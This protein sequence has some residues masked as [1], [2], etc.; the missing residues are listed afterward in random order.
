M[1]LTVLIK[2]VFVT[3]CMLLCGSTNILK[4]QNTLDA[5][6]D[7]ACTNNIVLMQKNISLEKAQMALK[8]ANSFF[9]PS[10]NFQGAYQTA[11]G[12]RNIPLPLGDLLNPVYTTLNQITQSD[13]FPMLE[14]EQINFFPKNFYDA[15]L[16]ATIPL[17]NTDLTYNKK[18]VQK[19]YTLKEYEVAIY[20][21]ELVRNVKTAYYNYLSALQ[22]VEIYQSAMKLTQEALRV[23]EK[24]LEN[25]KGLPAYV[26]RSKSEIENVKAQI[27]TAEQQ[28]KNAK[29]YFN[30]LLN[31]EADKEI[32]VDFKVDDELHKVNTMLL[33]VNDASLREEIKL[34]NQV[35]AINR[36]VNKLNKLYAVPKLGAFI[37][38]G[39]QSEGFKFNQNSRYYMAGLQLEIPIFSGNRNSYKIRESNLDI[40]NAELNSS[41]VYQQLNLAVKVAQNNLL[42]ANQNYQSSL[43][44]FES[45]AAYQRLI[46]KGYLAGSNSFV[47]TID[48]R[49]QFTGSKILTQINKYKVLIALA[50][51]ERETAAYAIK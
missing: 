45:A 23:N 48:A 2:D 43:K 26:L 19:Q 40:K 10:L 14:N 6:I 41:L 11:D 30:F 27:V 25:G 50:D 44:Q 46:D 39:S 5:Y 42:S 15:K 4:A 22:A 17:I 38:A 20:K 16:R 1:K 21:R 7:Q 12:G 34:T 29:M 3:V 9:L 8:T 49:N 32:E 18:I 36:D 31:R 37:D 35:A 47:E 13:K 51:L 24:L 33:T 28:V